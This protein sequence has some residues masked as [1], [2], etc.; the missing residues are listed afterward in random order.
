MDRV[1]GWVGAVWKWCG[2]W[3]KR[4]VT[5]GL[6]LAIATEAPRW[7]F[8]FVGANEP[9]AAGV[10]V[11]ILMAYAAAQGW[12]EYFRRRDALLLSLNL[13]QIASAL[14]IITPVVYAMALGHET[15]MRAVVAG[16]YLWVWCGT[17]VLST[18]LPLVVVA[19]V[20]VMR[21]GVIL[22]VNRI[23]AGAESTDSHGMQSPAPV[24]P[25]PIR[26]SEGAARMQELYD[27]GRGVTSAKALADAAGVGYETA[28][29][30]LRRNK[31]TV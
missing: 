27:G 12:D 4:N 8:A 18:F 6:V 9:V 30:W 21:H 10:A 19:Y 1:T 7:A 3:V 13:G 11:A 14:V 25:V 31:V 26:T 5:F 29:S 2:P 16:W 17:L 22:P 24:S 28:K 20:E 15:E 23:E